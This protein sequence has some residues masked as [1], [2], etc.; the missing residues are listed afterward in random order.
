MSAPSLAPTAVEHV[1]RHRPMQ[2][3]LAFAGR[4]I[5]DVINCPVARREVVLFFRVGRQ[6][7]RWG[8]TLE[9]EQQWNPLR[10]RVGS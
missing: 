7:Q 5:D 4:S 6:I 10:R 8:E 3:L 1:Q 9:L 2:Q